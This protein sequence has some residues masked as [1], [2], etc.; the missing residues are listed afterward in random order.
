VSAGQ[1][2]RVLQGS[3]LF[4]DVGVYVC[5][6]GGGVQTIEELESSCSKAQA[7]EAEL[8]RVRAE[9]N[10]NAGELRAEL[11]GLRTTLAA[12]DTVQASVGLSCERLLG[13]R[14]P[15]TP[16]AGVLVCCCTAAL[17]CV[18]SVQNQDLS[19]QC[20]GLKGTVQEQEGTIAQLQ[21]QVAQL[22]ASVVR[23]Y[24][25]AP[26]PPHLHSTSTPLHPVPCPSMC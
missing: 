9:A 12:L 8:A 13:F 6:W 11:E 7:V 4:V 23:C 20:E 2:W 1:S 14:S 22:Q 19:Q 15:P 3:Q 25:A 26:P 18:L 16:C 17:R 5:V 24:G 10:A 21:S